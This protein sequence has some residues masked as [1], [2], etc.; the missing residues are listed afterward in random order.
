MKGTTARGFA[1]LVAAMFLLGTAPAAFAQYPPAADEECVN[2]D[3]QTYTLDEVIEIFGTA[4]DPEVAPCFDSNSEGDVFFIQS[5]RHLA[6]FTTDEFGNY[7]TTGRI[8]SDARPGTA[9]IESRGTLDGQPVAYSKTVQIRPAQ[10]PRDRGEPVLPV[11]GTDIATL[12][13][14]GVAFVGIGTVLIGV[15]RRRRTR[16]EASSE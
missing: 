6:T 9:T 12:A 16:P 3:Q 7:A 2:T 11:T 4:D 8:P 10:A 5:E 14:W 1:G 13:A 15:R